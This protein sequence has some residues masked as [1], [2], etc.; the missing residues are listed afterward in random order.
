MFFACAVM[1]ARFLTTR[2]NIPYFQVLHEVHSDVVGLKLRLD[3]GL[4]NQM[5]ETLRV[6][7]DH[8]CATICCAGHFWMTIVTCERLQVRMRS[9]WWAIFLLDERLVEEPARSQNQLHR[10]QVLRVK[11]G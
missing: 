4:V 9:I 3:E 8:M 11:N 10:L 6:T 7:Q 2:R 5:N 1:S